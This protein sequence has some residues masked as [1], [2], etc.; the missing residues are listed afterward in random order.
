MIK[1]ITYQLLIKLIKE[2]FELIIPKVSVEIREALR[3]FLNELYKKAKES[4]NFWDDY[5]VEFI[6]NLLNIPLENQK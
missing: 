3:V 1:G 2:I 5:L 6:A 4:P